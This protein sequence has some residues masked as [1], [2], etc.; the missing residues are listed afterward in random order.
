MHAGHGHL[1]APMIWIG[2]IVAPGM[3]GPAAHF[4]QSPS[5]SV[6]SGQTIFHPL[7]IFTLP[8]LSVLSQHR[9]RTVKPCVPEIGSPP[10]SVGAWNV[11]STASERGLPV[12]RGGLRYSRTVF[13][14][15]V[16]SSPSVGQ[17]P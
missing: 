2:W 11:Y 17:C 16:K 14:S 8:P 4:G 12:C 5:H 9:R 3:S 6:P 7:R 15:T 13:P 1:P 10:Q